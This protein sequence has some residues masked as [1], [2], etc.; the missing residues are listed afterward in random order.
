MNNKIN[1][2]L[3]LL[4]CIF[5]IASISIVYGLNNQKDSKNKKIFLRSGTV[6]PDKIIS[7]DL[8]NTKIQKQV[9]N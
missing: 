4:L 9:K 5:L 7:N 1:K 8:I 2:T 6:I 3:L